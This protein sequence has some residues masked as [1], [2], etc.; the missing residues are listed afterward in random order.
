[1]MKGHMLSYPPFSFWGLDREVASPLPFL[2]PPQIPHRKGLIFFTHLSLP[3]LFSLNCQKQRRWSW[4]KLTLSLALYK[5]GICQVKVYSR[6]AK[7]CLNWNESK[8]SESNL[9][10]ILGIILRS[11][12]NVMLNTLKRSLYCEAWLECLLG[13]RKLLSMVKSGNSY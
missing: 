8:F 2:P 4:G 7:K 9:V 1:M 6:Y 12:R 10:V 13:P 11:I 3:Q 5:N